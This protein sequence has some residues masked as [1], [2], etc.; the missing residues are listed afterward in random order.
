[1][2]KILVSFWLCFVVGVLVVIS[3]FYL[4]ASGKMGYMPSFEELENPNSSISTEVI[5]TDNQII[6]K[7]YLENRS[8]I[9][10]ENINPNLK[11]AVLAT[12][13]IRFFNHTGV[14]FRALL[15]VIKGVVGDGGGGG[16]TITQQLAKNLFPRE[17]LNKFQLVFRKLKE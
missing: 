5:S 11:N 14:D 3:L 8:N 1:M 7:F 4:I 17:R 6:G 10:F 15:R 13:D 2:K 12:E 16:S 9:V